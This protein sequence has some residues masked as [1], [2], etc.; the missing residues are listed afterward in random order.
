MALK[1]NG[2]K[3]WIFQRFSNM[4]ILV[5]AVV[6]IGLFF[7]LETVDYASWQAMHGAMWFKLFATFTLIVVMINSILA[8]WQ[9]GTDYTQKV[10]IPAFSPLFHS[11]YIL[12]SLAF[13]A[14]G[15]YILWFI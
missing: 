5:F 1:R 3:E 12:G 13:L 4:L 14:F 10:P 8:G 7:S 11:F 6:Y 9:I 15:L 2:V